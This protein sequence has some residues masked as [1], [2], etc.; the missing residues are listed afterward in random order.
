MIVDHLD[1][2]ALYAPMHPLF[3]RAFDAVRGVCPSTA[4]PGTVVLQENELILMI[5]RPAMKLP[6]K[7]R[8]E[9]HDEMIDLHVPL[10]GTEGF[11]WKPRAA[12]LDPAEPYHAGKD[13]RHY[14]DAPDTRFTLKPGQFALFFPGDAHAGC[15]GEG[16][17]L[18]V[19]VKIR[20]SRSV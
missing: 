7:A 4:E 16:E 17:L 5:S 11:A 9:V 10:S 15:V 13:A 3:Q 19:V 8:L 6:E 20:A 1:A 12:L 18:K 14:L 2:S